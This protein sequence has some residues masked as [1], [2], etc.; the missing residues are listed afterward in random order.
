LA[1]HSDA[2]LNIACDWYVTIVF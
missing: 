1:A 2:I